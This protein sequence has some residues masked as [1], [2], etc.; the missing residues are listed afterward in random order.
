MS[1]LVERANLAGKRAIV[2]GGGEGVGRAVSLALAHEGVDLA[3][4]DWQ[5]APLADTCAAV[6]GLG[7]QVVSME[8]DVRER[9]ALFAF[10]DLVDRE[11][12]SAQILVNLPGGVRRAPFMETT[13]EQHENE[14]RLN[15]GYVIDSVQRAVPLIRRGGTGGSIVNF[16]TIE[17]GRGAAGFAVYGGAKAAVYNFS[18]CLAVELA[19]ERIRV[20]VI[21]PDSTPSQ[22]SRNAIDSSVW[23]DMAALPEPVRQAGTRMTIPMATRPLE[24][25]LADAVVFLASDL[26]AYITGISL[27]VDAGTYA[28]SGFVNWPFGEG[29]MPG[30]RAATLRKLFGDGGPGGA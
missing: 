12:G 19:A 16:T 1:K 18:R 6:R 17:A 30:P 11:W 27:P 7:R 29:Y 5:G 13:I 25:D 14:I 15:Y 24:P 26:S 2:V 9:A 8:V 20:N 22:T 23:T 10:Y 4:C 28:A 3:I 21:A